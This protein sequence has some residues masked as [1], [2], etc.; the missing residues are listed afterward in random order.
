MEEHKR[1]LSLLPERLRLAAEGCVHDKVEEFRLRLGRE[2]VFLAAGTET[3]FS[4]QTVTAEELECILERATGASMHAAAQAMREGYISF[5]GLRIGVCG[6]V[7]H[8]AGKM[9]GFQ[10][11]SSLAI[12][13][14]REC[15][16]MCERVIT[17]LYS[18]SF[19]NTLIVSP[20]GGGKTTALRDMIRGLSER[21]YRLGVVDERN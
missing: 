1:A 10:T 4:E 17:Q 12:R 9:E 18:L 20:P 5:E 15:K 3:S 7:L 16:G 11:V 13:I 21:G 6:T 14:S 2:P 19:Q 8:R